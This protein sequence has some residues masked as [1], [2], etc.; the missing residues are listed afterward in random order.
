MSAQEIG[1]RISVITPCLNGA[2]YIG[3]AIE[4]V[5]SQRYPN[6]EHI[7]VDGG[8]TDGT[9]EVLRRYSHL[10]VL[11][12]PDHGLYDALNKALAAAQGEI[13]GILNSDDCYAEDAFSSINEAFQDESVMALAG[14]AVFCRETVKSDQSV[15]ARFTPAGTDLL[16]LSTLGSPAIN[17]W[18]FRSS[19][20][21]KL[22][23]FDKSYKVAGDREFMLR[24]AISGLRYAETTKLICRYRMHA[25][26]MTFGGN[27]AI[28]QTILREHTKMT[29]IYLHRRDLSKR[30][31]ELIR[32]ARTRDTLSMAVRAMRRHDMV[33]L[34]LSSIAGTRHDPVWP[35]RLARQVLAALARKLRLR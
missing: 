33:T 9:L 27:E 23:R 18:F 6:T 14:E 8:S 7:V 11:H 3:E 19:I 22:G 29:G 10:K 25:D 20:F 12:G 21:A 31:R 4:S 26:S 30:A 34:V 1:P 17:A 15:A 2:R 5:L 13:V 35:I 28:W 16:F 24:F 32:R